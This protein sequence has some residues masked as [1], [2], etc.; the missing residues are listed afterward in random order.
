MKSGSRA[1]L[2]LI[3]AFIFISGCAGTGS[4]N[5]SGIV[6]RYK[7]VDVSHSH[8]E[9][10]TTDLVAAMIQLPAAAPFYTTVQFSE[11]SNSLGK[12]LLEAMSASGYGIQMVDADQGANYVTYR[13]SRNGAVNDGS[14]DYSVK[15]ND[16]EISRKYSIRDNQIFPISELIISGTK[17]SRII[18]SNT[19]FSYQSGAKVFPSGVTFLGKDGRVISTEIRPV[20]SSK[21]DTG[22]ADAYLAAQALLIAKASTFTLAR[23]ASESFSSY[24][25][26]NFRT[27]KHLRM[28]FRRKNLEMGIPNKKALQNLVDDFNPSEHMFLITG[29]S[30]GKSMIWDGTES[31]ALSRSQRVKEEL[32]LHGIS[33]DRIREES[34]FQTEYGKELLPN[35]VIVTLKKTNDLKII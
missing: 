14:V 3:C 26:E 1:I 33:G 4:G 21:S 9:K 12:L 5:S 35:A 22:Y 19:V 7:A 29:C 32:L 8:E 16:L 27:I 10:I 13:A 18:V 34:C 28:K 31:L 2:L 15:I 23:L 25:A 30:H 17:P 6:K 24:R 11:P 20:T